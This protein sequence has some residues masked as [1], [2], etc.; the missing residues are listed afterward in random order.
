MSTRRI[1]YPP[2]VESI[3]EAAQQAWTSRRGFG[4]P[5]ATIRSDFRPVYDFWCGWATRPGV[6]AETV[7]A[8]VEELIE[9]SRPGKG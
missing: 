1:T 4:V 2:Q 6:T 3:A 7:A 5:W 9:T 8:R